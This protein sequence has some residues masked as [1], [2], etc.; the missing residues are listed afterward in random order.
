MVEGVLFEYNTV[1]AEGDSTESVRC[2]LSFPML[3]DN[4]QTIDGVNR[5]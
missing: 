3:K 1:H 5:D 2:A 4:Q